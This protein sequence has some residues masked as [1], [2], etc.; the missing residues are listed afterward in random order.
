[1]PPA[2][3]RDRA[4][5]LALKGMACRTYAGGG[6]RLLAC[7]WLGSPPA[8][9]RGRSGARRLRPGRRKRDVAAAAGER[10]GRGR[11]RAT[12]SAPAGRDAVGA[13]RSRRR[14]SALPEPAR[15]LPD[16]TLPA[17]GPDGSRSPW[18]M[19][20][21]CPRLPGHGPQRGGAAGRAGAL[22]GRSARTRSHAA[23]GGVAGGLSLCP[24]AG[25]AEPDLL[26]ERARAPDTKPGSACRCSRPA[27]RWTRKARRRWTRRWTR[28][29]PAAPRMGVVAHAGHVGVTNALGGL[30]ATCTPTRSPSGV[31]ATAWRR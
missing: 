27:A 20:R 8:W 12:S 24:R 5:R 2:R 31:V 19:P 14:S 28:R 11:G 13:H 16:G 18:C 26:L 29:G 21:A 4:R 30:P 7:A 10:A 9:W 23:A 3:A 22:R 1:M 15:I 17:I 25:P 6:F